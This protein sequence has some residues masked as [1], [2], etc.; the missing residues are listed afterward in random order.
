MHSFPPSK[1][2]PDFLVPR[3][4]AISMLALARLKTLNKWSLL[5]RAAWEI[6]MTEATP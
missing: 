6:G 5:V 3:L 4:W 2:G 1:L